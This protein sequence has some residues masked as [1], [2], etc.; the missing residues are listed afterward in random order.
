MTFAASIPRVCPVCSASEH[1]QLQEYCVTEWPVA[2]CACCD[3]VY[4][5]RGIEYTALEEDYA[6]E[7]SFAN[8]RVR[9]SK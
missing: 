5:S 2:Q 7:K 3:L 1:R 8:E 6:W 4:L 9:R